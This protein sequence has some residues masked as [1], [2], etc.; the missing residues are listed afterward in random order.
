VLKVLQDSAPPI[1]FKEI[2]VV[3]ENDLQRNADDIFSNIDEN[4]IA[5]ASLAQ[6]HKAT[7]K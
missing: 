5:A 3:I 7:L 6:V 4:A 2:R 1:S